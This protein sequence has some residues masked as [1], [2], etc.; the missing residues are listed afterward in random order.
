VGEGIKKKLIEEGSLLFFVY[1]SAVVRWYT[2]EGNERR[3]KR[4]KEWEKKVKNDQDWFFINYDF[5]EFFF[6]FSFIFFIQRFQRWWKERGKKKS[7]RKNLSVVCRTACLPNT[8]L[9]PLVKFWV[10]N[11]HSFSWPVE[12]SETFL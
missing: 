4:E 5:C 2:D 12:K 7:S 10:W 8:F 9:L 6:L 3:R 11:Q 1:S